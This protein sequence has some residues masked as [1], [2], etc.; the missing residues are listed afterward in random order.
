MNYD[1]SAFHR[2]VR[3]ER[4][5]MLLKKLSYVCAATLVIV[6]LAG[7]GTKE[8]DNAA[9]KAKTTDN[10]ST[11]TQAPVDSNVDVTEKPEVTETP[12]S[13]DTSKDVS[14]LDT[15]SPDAIIESANALQKKEIDA[16]KSEWESLKGKVDSYKSFVNKEE[17]IE[18]CH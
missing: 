9:N 4:K 13:N 18:Q 2:A 10:S 17:E 15:S 11:Q 5:I 16:L 3:K 12:Q 6:S 14:T 7:C 8:N 1:E